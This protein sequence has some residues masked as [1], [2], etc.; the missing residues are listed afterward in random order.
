MT[1]FSQKFIKVLGRQGKKERNLKQQYLRGNREVRH[2]LQHTDKLEISS[3]TVLR[4]L[5]KI[6]LR[7]RVTSL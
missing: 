2:S 5:R 4:I 6:D 3:E 1:H 7:G